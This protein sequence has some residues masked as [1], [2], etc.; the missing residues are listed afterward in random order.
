MNIFNQHYSLS[1][2]KLITDFELLPDAHAALSK[3]QAAFTLAEILITIG[4]I[5]VVAAMTMPALINKYQE[6]VTVTKVKKFYSLISQVVMHARA[7]YGDVDCWDLEG[8]D[9]GGWDAVSAEKLAN[10]LLAYIHIIKNCTNSDKQCIQSGAITVLN[11]TTW[12][13]YMSAGNYYKMILKDGS[14]MWFRTSKKPCEDS[15]GGFKNV[16]AVIWYDTNGNKPP[17]TTGKDV[18]VFYILKDRVVPYAD[19]NDCNSEGNGWGCANYILSNGNMNYL[20]K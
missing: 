8:T 17:Y 2:N 12:V 19:D 10:Y 6:K 5:G 7:D 1:S 15:D 4:I 9:G 20:K 13:N 14:L 16:C 3:R 11:G 18:F